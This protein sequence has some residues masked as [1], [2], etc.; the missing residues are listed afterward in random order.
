MRHT[1]RDRNG[2]LLGWSERNGDRLTGRNRNG[3]LVGWYEISR[4]ETRDR[5]GRLVG[6]GNLLAGLIAAADQG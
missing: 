5:D 1:Y 6:H 3:R 4:D 2:L